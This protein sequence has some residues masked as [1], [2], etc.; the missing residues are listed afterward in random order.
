[1]G[2]R[3]DKT[4]VLLVAADL[5]NEVDRVED[6]PGDDQQ[7]EEDSKDEQR[8]LSPV[9][10]DPP[11]IE[12]DGQGDQ[13]RTENGKEVDRFSIALQNHPSLV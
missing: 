11:D 2:D 13:A 6:Q 5:A 10:D 8:Q 3:I 9:K 12:R 7:K 1:M 4:V